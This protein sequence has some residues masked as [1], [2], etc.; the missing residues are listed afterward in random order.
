MAGRKDAIFFRFYGKVKYYFVTL[1]I[2]HYTSEVPYFLFQYYYYYFYYYFPLVTKNVAPR[3]L[4]QE[5]RR[6]IKSKDFSDMG[7]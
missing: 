6:Q 1:L 5:N 3:L 7:C 4:S 2:H